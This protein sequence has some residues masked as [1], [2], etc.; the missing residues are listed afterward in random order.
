MPGVSEP[1]SMLTGPQSSSPARTPAE[2]A[3]SGPSV[4]TADLRVG[5]AHMWSPRAPGVG[6]GEHLPT[7]SSQRGTSG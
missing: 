1:G 5:I 4:R 6:Q 7:T 2:P 3:G